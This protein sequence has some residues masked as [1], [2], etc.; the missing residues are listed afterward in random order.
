MLGKHG[1]MLNVTNMNT[2]LVQK[3]GVI[4]EVLATLRYVS[5]Q[6]GPKEFQRFLTI[7]PEADCPGGIEVAEG[8]TLESNP[9]SGG[10]AVEG[11]PLC[12]SQAFKGS[13][14]FDSCRVDHIS[15]VFKSKLRKLSLSSN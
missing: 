3:G 8:N 15:P 9:S 7:M 10:L 5:L 11:E 12:R 4:H 6:K 2:Q 14:S 1:I 13:L